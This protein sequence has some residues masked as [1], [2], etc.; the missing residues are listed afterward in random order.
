MPDRI[1]AAR[2]PR[3]LD[4][5]PGSYWWCRCGRSEGQPWCDGSHKGTGIEP[6]ELVVDKPRKAALCMCKATANEPM[7]DGAHRLLSAD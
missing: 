5:E 7:C 2:T 1:I 4:L 3:V 6:M